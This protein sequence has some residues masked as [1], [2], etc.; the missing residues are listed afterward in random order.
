MTSPSLPAPGGEGSEMAPGTCLAPP[1]ARD[2]LVPRGIFWPMWGFKNKRLS[3]F[4]TWHQVIV[5]GFSAM[6]E[7]GGLPDH[8][9]FDYS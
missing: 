4:L 7:L 3:W 5:P 2:H 1:A 8:V 6:L 9:C